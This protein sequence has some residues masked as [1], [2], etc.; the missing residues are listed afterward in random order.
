[1]TEANIDAAREVYVPV[2][3]QGSIHFFAITDLSHIDPMYQYSLP[4]FIGM[5]N[6]C[7]AKAP[8]AENQG[9]RVEALISFF[10]LSMFENICRSLFNRHHI[11]YSFNLCM[12]VLIARGTVQPHAYPLSRQHAGNL[13][14]SH[15]VPAVAVYRLEPAADF[16][17][18]VI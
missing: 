8:S 2:S 4:F 6:S 17:G 10:M 13:K 11:L 5:F 18:S 16:E 12:K 14:D 1:M 3:E 7:N 15:T 9:E